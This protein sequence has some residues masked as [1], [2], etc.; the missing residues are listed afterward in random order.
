MRDAFSFAARAVY[1]SFFFSSRSYIHL[2]QANKRIPHSKT[3]PFL[4]EN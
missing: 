1:S 4:E 2:N 3:L